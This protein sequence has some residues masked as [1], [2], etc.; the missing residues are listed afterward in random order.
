MSWA[1][2]CALVLTL[3]CACEPGSAG[4]S[5]A[6]SASP[7]GAA[8]APGSS[9]AAEQVAKAALTFSIEGQALRSL[10]RDELVAGVPPVTFTAFD[11]YY[12]KPKTFRALPLRPL[13]EL[14]F[15]GKQVALEESHFVLRAADGYTVPIE[16]KRLLEGGAHLAIDD[17]DVSDGWQPIGPRQAD[18]GPFYLVWSGKEQQ[19]LETHPRP[20]QLVAIEISSF[21]RT[22]PRTVPSGLAAN[23]PALAGFALFRQQCIHCHAINRQGGS[24]GPEL[25]VPQSIVEYRPAEQI[26]AYIKNPLSFR[27]GNMPP[28]PGLTDADL[29]ALLAYFVAMSERKQDP[30]GAPGGH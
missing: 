1:R 7:T 18:P 10:S 15:A 19:D 16:G 4:P 13:L 22:F 8:T 3:T 11:P 26:K 27:Y 6:T 30:E 12:N 28:H 14:G 20:W 29:D 23:S 25:N 2:R 9:P 5:S 21:E 24:V 17:L